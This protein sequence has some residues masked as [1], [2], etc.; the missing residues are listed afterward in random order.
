MDIERLKYPHH[1]CLIVMTLY[2]VAVWKSGNE[3][4]QKITVLVMASDPHTAL[5][6]AAEHPN[7]EELYDEEI[8]RAIVNHEISESRVGRKYSDYIKQVEYVEDE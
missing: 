3:Y 8:Q 7:A 5:D 2:R 4:P 6:N 1:Y